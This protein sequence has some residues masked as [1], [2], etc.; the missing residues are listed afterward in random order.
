MPVI[1]LQPDGE[2]GTPAW[3][4]KGGGTNDVEVQEG[5]DNEDDTAT[6]NTGAR[7][8]IDIL[9]LD[10]TPGDFSVAVDYQ[11]RTFAKHEGLVDDTSVNLLVRVTDAGVDIDAN[12]DTL[13]ITGAGG[14][15]A[16]FNGAVRTNTDAQA[17]WDGYEIEYQANLVTS[18]MPDDVTW[19]LTAIEVIV[20]YDLATGVAQD[21][22]QLPNQPQRVSIGVVPSGPGPL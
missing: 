1:T 3:I 13:N 14:T 16:G 12:Q 4:P 15:Y 2:F 19:H 20:N 22:E 9:E 5:V 6:E 7:N 21:F 8:D 18:G 17:A 11:I 10:A